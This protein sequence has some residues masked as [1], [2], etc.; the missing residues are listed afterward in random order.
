MASFKNLIS[1]TS[2]QISSGGTIT[3]DL[4]INGDLQVDGGGSL[5]FDEIIEGT[6]VIDVTSTEALLVRKNGDGGDVFVV[7]TT[8]SRAIFGGDLGLGV[9]PANTSNYKTLDIRDSTGGQIIL[10]RSGN[11]DFFMYSA[12]AK[13]VIG[14]GSS[15]ELA[16]H[17][18]SDGASN[19][20]LR[21]D[22]SGNVGIGT[23]S[24]DS[25]HKLTIKTS[26]TGGD[27]IIG[28]Q[29]DG[30]Q[31]FR[32]G[33]D[34][35][36]D[37][38]FELGSAGTS[39]AVVL[40][41]D[42]DSH[43]NGGNVGIGTSSPSGKLTLSNGSAS[44]PLSITASNSYIQLGSEDFGSGGLGKFMIGFGYTDVLTNT[45]APAY[46]GF[47]ETSTSGDTKGDL[48]FYTRNVTT[49]TLPTKR[50]TI[51]ADGSST[52]SGA[53]TSGGNVTI[54]AGN[55]LYLD[56]GS[57]TY[58]YQETDNKIS[59]ATNSGVRLSIDNSSA[60][61]S[62]NLALSASSP[63]INFSGSSGDYGTFGYT[64]GDPDVF[65]W[66]LFQNSGQ[67]ASI[68]MD[69]VSEASPSARFRFNVGGDTDS[70]LLI[71]SSKRVGIGTSNPVA[72][73]VV[74]DGGNAGIELQPEIATDTNRITNYDRTA[75]AYMNFRLDALTQQF[76]ISGTERMR[77]D[78]N[79]RISLSNNDSGTS[80]TIFGRTAGDSIVSGG[81]NNT[82]F[83]FNA[84]SSI[85]TGDG[86][87]LLG[88][89]AGETFDTNG[90]N[91]GIGSQALGGNGNAS[92][93][94]AIGATAL[95]GSLSSN[96][97]G[98]VAVGTS[99]LTSLTS[100]ADNVSV[101]YI[102]QGDLTTGNYN[103]SLGNLSLQRNTDGGN[104]VALGYAAGKFDASSNNVTSPD[105]CIAIGANTGFSTATP[106]NQIAI[107]HNVKGLKDNSITLGNANITDVYMASDSEAIVHCGGV[108]FPDTQIASSDV[109]Q[110]D[111]YEE[112]EHT[113]TITGTTSGSW[114]LDSAQN[115][116]SY[117]KIGRL[118]TVIGKFETDSGSGAGTL[119]ISMPFTAANLTS[120]AGIAA[121]SITINRY[122]ST[123]IATQ[124]TPIIFEGNNFI[125]VQIHSTDG[126]SNESYVQADDIDAIFEG[127]LSITYFTD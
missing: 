119:K 114:V 32:I 24:P 38:F 63:Q 109:N 51:S 108:R 15:A 116:L 5:S 110:L 34:S 117:T 70:A 80:N 7:D 52:F 18:N 87:V 78:S 57:D 56:G 76:L 8:N 26:A 111:D 77:L 42:G 124:I 103:T 50:L 125:N 62:G 85:T 107:G 81:N 98:T 94:V 43:F 105:Q 61:F 41:A 68:T 84:G 16:F 35:G 1:N 96:A 46:I 64:E 69:A 113:T 25:S 79:S 97:D 47:E 49:D 115:K 19:E 45:N 9:T 17:T 58:I 67:I 29:S 100:G 10:G 102:S 101:G 126:T 31:G 6:Q 40:Q 71:D 2:A 88:Y 66:A 48:T 30:G 83:G 20:R 44:A 122:G 54:P 22:S 121:G 91:V 36:D 55:L 13:T 118:V 127:Q 112:G 104:N 39:N 65:K 120:G 11:T 123:S 82:L 14:S 33:A 53:I 72:K 12:S 4:V 74:S 92:N 27:W 95:L 89:R 23:S 106:G 93:C 21:I 86:N 3:G 75:S 37:A 99:A 28:Q 59:F 60:T 73:L 90:N